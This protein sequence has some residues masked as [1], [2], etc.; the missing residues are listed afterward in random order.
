MT[1]KKLSVDTH[2][3]KDVVVSSLTRDASVEACIFDLIDNAIDAARDVLEASH[4]LASDDHG[5]PLSYDGLKVE[6]SINGNGVSIKD[7]CGGISPNE[8]SKM[9][10]RFGIK[11][12]RKYG[13]GLYGVG[14]NRA[15]FKLGNNVKFETDDGKK[16]SILEFS[17]IDYLASDEWNLPATAFPSKKQPGTNIA[18]QNPPKNVL[19]FIS[20]SFWISEFITEAEKRYFKFI[21]KGFC[22]HINKTQLKPIFVPIRENGPFPAFNKF[23]KTEDGVTVFIEAGQ[24]HL[25]RFTA[26]P[27]SDLKVNKL[28]TD[29][30]GWSVICNDRLIVMSDTS[31]KTGWEKKWHPE[32][33]GFVGYVWFVAEDG[34]HL[35]WNT[36]KTDVDRLSSV[37]Q[38]AVGDMRLFTEKWRSYGRDAKAIRKRGE[39]LLPPADRQREETQT[40]NGS[41]VKKVEP[42]KPSPSNTDKSKAPIK[43]KVVPKI[44][45][46]SLRAVLPSDVDQRHCKDKLLALV[47]EGQKI[48]MYDN[49]YSGLALIRMLFET[50][51]IEFMIRTQ[52][53]AHMR[54]YCIEEKERKSGKKMSAARAKDYQPSI[55]ELCDYVLNHDV[56]GMQKKAYIKK[57]AERFKKHK[58]RLN[59]A[60]H[61]PIQQINF[62]TALEIRDEVIPVLRHFIE[63]NG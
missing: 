29:E 39:K 52:K 41:G 63:D 20:D 40:V 50:S 44:D 13:I 9:V 15:I 23:Y 21:T 26:E 47:H 62:T 58:E 10:L 56:W 54:A 19:K 57:S 45:H 49:T 60:I 48:D 33:N 5:L 18:I 28:L 8:L 36:S 42:S 11:S 27:D 7:N 3:T 37:F 4:S 46:N 53:A 1:G 31:E 14:L 30:Y 12:N 32:F 38:E 24:H 35:P 2:P 55:D 16:L 34:M 25:H 43:K 17:T 22:I 6:L 51:V 59:S 61:N